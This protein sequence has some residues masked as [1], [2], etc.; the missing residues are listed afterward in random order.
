M[1]ELIPQERI[2]QRIFVIRG[3]KVMIGMHLAELYNVTTGALMQAIKR[4][5]DRFP[6]DFM[7]KLT[8]KEIMRISQIVISLK[9]SKSVYAFTEQGIAMLSSVLHSKRAIQVNIAIMRAF[10]KIRQFL[11]TH[12]DLARKL[13]EL[14]KKTA[15]HDTEIQAIFDAI[16]QL[17]IPPKVGS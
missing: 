15:R 10:V 11:S 5:A 13:E 16:K 17:M 2:E 3:Y 7:F 14:E 9:Y 1:K 4:N 8:R 6:D 12:K